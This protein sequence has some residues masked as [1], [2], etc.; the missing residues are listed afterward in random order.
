MIQYVDTG[1]GEYRP[2]VCNI[3]PAE[4][5]RRRQ[6]GYLGLAAAVAVAAAL[7]ALD[8][9]AWTRLIIALPVA[10][11]LSGF[12]Q[13]Q[14]RFCAGFAMSGLQNMGELGEQVRVE[15]AAARAADR[16]KAILIHGASIAGGLAA[17]IAFALLPI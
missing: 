8:A 2:G 14:Q 13:A 6:I 11:A 16:R 12:I 1:A 17:G 10:G 5:R 9:P 3:G 15:D 7:L 4:I